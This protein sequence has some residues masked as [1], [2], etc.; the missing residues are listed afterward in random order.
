[1]SRDQVGVQS[2][3]Y[4]AVAKPHR[5]LAG[6]P[7]LGAISLTMM[8]GVIDVGGERAFYL[9]RIGELGVI[10]RLGIG[11]RITGSKLCL[12]NFAGED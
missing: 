5:K 1:M 7:A 12:R 6:K 2:R 9:G 8:A 11:K 4:A 3:P 10:A